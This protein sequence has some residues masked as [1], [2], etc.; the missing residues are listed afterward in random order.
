M[1]N[2]HRNEGVIQ[3]KIHHAVM[4]TVA[5]LLTVRI[6]IHPGGVLVKMVH[7]VMISIVWLVIHQIVRV[8]VGTIV[9]VEIKNRV[10]LIYIRTQTN[11][12][13]TGNNHVFN[14]MESTFLK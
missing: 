8:N 6:N 12:S 1:I 3:K 2:I 4:V 5:M 14:R 10:V 13:R 9:N 7:N 11:P